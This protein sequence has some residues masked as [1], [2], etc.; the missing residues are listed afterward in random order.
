MPPA[1]VNEVFLGTVGHLQPAISLAF[2]SAMS[3]AFIAS[4]LIC[5]LAIF[6]SIVR[7]GKR[8]AAATTA[9]MPPVTSGA[10]FQPEDASAEVTEQ[11]TGGQR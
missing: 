2:S 1:L 3:H 8:I 10:S 4:A 9:A 6:F 7:E 11:R 5:L